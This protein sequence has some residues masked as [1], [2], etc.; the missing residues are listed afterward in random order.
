MPDGLTVDAEGGIWVALYGGGAVRRYLPNGVLDVIVTLPVTQVT[1]CV[2]GGADLD[3]LYMTTSRE[4]LAESEQPAAG[5]STKRD[6]G[7]WGSLRG[8]S[9]GEDL[10][11][12]WLPSPRTGSPQFYGQAPRLCVRPQDAAPSSLTVAA[13]RI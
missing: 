5:F 11:S 10:G 13:P 7:C 3:E 4:G 2:F 8:C 9:M 12:R 6:P 1:S